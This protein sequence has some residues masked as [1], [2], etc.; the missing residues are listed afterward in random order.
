MKQFQMFWKQY[1]EY[2]AYWNT[3]AEQEDR[4]IPVDGVYTPS[5]EGFMEWLDT[6]GENISLSKQIIP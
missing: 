6:H 5:F 4:P 2:V 3:K 1:L